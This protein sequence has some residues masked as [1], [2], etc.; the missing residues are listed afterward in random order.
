MHQSRNFSFRT[1]LYVTH[2]QQCG[3]RFCDMVGKLHDGVDGVSK[4]EVAF[5]VCIIDNVIPRF[6]FLNVFND[7]NTFPATEL[8]ITTAK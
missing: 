4:Q 7:S 6:G 2:G 3:S 5:N 8:T 1:M